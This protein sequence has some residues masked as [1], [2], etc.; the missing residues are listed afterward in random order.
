MASIND[1]YAAAQALPASERVKLISLLW[2]GM[3]PEDWPTPSEVWI[4]EANRRSDAIDSGEMAVAS[5]N[6]ARQRARKKAGL[7]D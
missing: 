1:I 7:D 4:E 2:D 6:D 5:W 3:E